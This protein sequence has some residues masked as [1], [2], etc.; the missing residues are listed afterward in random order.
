MIALR[1][2]VKINAQ[3]AWPVALWRHHI[4][5]CQYVEM[6]AVAATV[7]YKPMTSLSLLSDVDKSKIINVP[8]AEMIFYP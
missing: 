7:H 4:I 1:M 6:L 2:L 3:I 5:D 8:Y